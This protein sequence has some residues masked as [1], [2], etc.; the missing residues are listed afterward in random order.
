MSGLIKVV[1]HSYGVFNNIQISGKQMKYNLCS[2]SFRHE[3]VSIE[4]LIKF[5][6]ET[7]F[8][9]IEMWGVHAMGLSKNPYVNIEE[10]RNLC[11]LYKIQIPMISDYVNLLSTDDLYEKEYQRFC[12]LIEIARFFDVKGI[13]IFAGNIPSKK[14]S[15]Q[16][17]DLCIKR[18]VEITDLT[19]RND[20]FLAIENHPNT[21][22]D[23]F[24][25]IQKFI[26]RINHPGFKINFDILHIWEHGYAPLDA[27]LG[28]KKWIC[29]FHF[30]NI[31]DSSQ[32]DVF[33]P[34]NVYSPFGK[35]EG[36]TELN[37]GQIDYTKIIEYLIREGLDL[38]ISLEWFGGDSFFYLKNEIEWLRRVESSVNT[39]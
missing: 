29:N 36:I 26:S 2:I 25:C 17:W 6:S 28:L 19:F 14:A 10:C 11:K 24:S 7:G 23:D 32:L 34:I 27:L 3:L 35:R 30:K 33:H 38:P 16:E 22:A 12:D 1:I 13:R 8:H 15:D 20:L 4:S 5:A 21:M 31:L 9:G 18:L 37:N 39:K